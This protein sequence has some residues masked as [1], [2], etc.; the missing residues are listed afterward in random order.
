M[1]AHLGYELYVLV[2]LYDV[3]HQRL[4]CT[5]LFLDDSQGEWYPLF[6][7]RLGLLLELVKPVE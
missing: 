2:Q 6:H 7:L 1:H 4:F 5:P 3:T